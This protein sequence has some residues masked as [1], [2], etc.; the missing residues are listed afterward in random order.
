MAGNTGARGEA[1]IKQKTAK[2][3]AFLQKRLTIYFD[4]LETALIGPCAAIPSTPSDDV[5]IVT[6]VTRVVTACC[7]L[8]L[9]RAGLYVLERRLVGRWCTEA[10]HALTSGWLG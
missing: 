2:A 1:Q 7:I 4:S 8:K 9:F 6:E 5:N 10:T 3:P